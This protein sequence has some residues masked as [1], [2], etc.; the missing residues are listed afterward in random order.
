MK[1]S[2][3]DKLK[4]VGGTCLLSTMLYTGV[5]SSYSPSNPLHPMNPTN[6]TSPIFH[7]MGDSDG[8]SHVYEEWQK[9]MEEKCGKYFTTE[10]VSLKKRNECEINF[11]QY[12]INSKKRDAT[13][14]VIGGITFFA[15]IFASF[16]FMEWYDNRK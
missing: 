4:V 2:I 11:K 10:E 5:A 9:S 12:V 15:L 7:R 6:P 13:Y 3:T 1:Y 14:V 16:K 8:N